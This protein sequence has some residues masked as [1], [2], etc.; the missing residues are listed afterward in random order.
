MMGVAHR[1]AIAQ[2]AVHGQ[3]QQKPPSLS[4]S[5]LSIV[6]HPARAAIA[7][8]GLTRACPLL[9]AFMHPGAYRKSQWI[10][11]NFFVASVVVVVLL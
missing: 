7:H 4:F 1:A 3:G 8:A 11:E 5:P 10:T 9:N 6:H 2:P